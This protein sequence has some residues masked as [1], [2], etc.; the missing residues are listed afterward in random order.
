MIQDSHCRHH[1]FTGLN[2]FLLLHCFFFLFFCQSP[3]PSLLFCFLK[4]FILF[5]CARSNMWAIDIEPHLPFFFLSF[6]M[7]S[8]TYFNTC[9]TYPLFCFW[10]DQI[11]EPLSH[12]LF[13]YLFMGSLIYFST[14][15]NNSS[16][17]NFC[18]LITNYLF[19]IIIII[20]VFYYYY[21]K[22]HA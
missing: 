7:G 4:G 9:H 2:P 20:W 15:V 22:K 13:I 14:S 17:K 6:L 12:I 3:S 21:I 8:Y 11:R 5:F 18:V 10:V 1:N 16:V 19:I